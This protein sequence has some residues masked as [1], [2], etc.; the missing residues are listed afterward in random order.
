MAA[1]TRKPLINEKDVDKDVDED[2]EDDDENTPPPA[3]SCNYRVTYPD[4]FIELHEIQ[5]GE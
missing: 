4:I 5:D 3:N 1:V 2:E